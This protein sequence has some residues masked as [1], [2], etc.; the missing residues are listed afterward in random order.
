MLESFARDHLP[1]REYPLLSKRDAEHASGSAFTASSLPSTT[2]HLPPSL[3]GRLHLCMSQIEPDSVQTTEREIV[4]RLGVS[5]GL[6]PPS[7]LVPGDW[8]AD[9]RL[10][11]VVGTAH[12]PASDGVVNASFR[13]PPARPMGEKEGVRVKHRETCWRVRGGLSIAVGAANTR[14]MCGRARGASDN[15]GMIESAE[16]RH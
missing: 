7:G 4:V 16:C 2:S 3:P 12:R 10:L 1:G 9:K 11:P 15:V 5:R 8:F 13:S 14:A 6:A